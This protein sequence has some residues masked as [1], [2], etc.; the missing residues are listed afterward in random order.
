MAAISGVLFDKDGTL[1]DF[2]QSWTLWTL[3]L[4]Q[5]LAAGDRV[6]QGQMAAELGFD[7]D[8]AAFLPDSPVIAGTP[9]E[10]A[11]CLIPLLPGMSKAA[12]LTR[13]NT[14]AA[15]ANMHEV[16]PLD[17]FLGGLR[18]MGLRV[19]VATNDAEAP[20]VAHLKQ[21]GI[22]DILDF[23]AGCDSGYG[24]KPSAGPL[25]A[26]ADMFDLDP[27]HVVM[28]G[29]SRHDLVAARLAGMRPVA[30]LTGLARESELADLAETVLDSVADL[31]GWL[32]LNGLGTDALPLAD[33]PGDKKATRA[34]A[35]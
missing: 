35:S 27:G 6:R 4:L 8:R 29:D 13:M 25:L 34:V 26:F 30:V 33:C 31:P 14:L 15:E 5:E 2:E 18:G 17:D 20:A 12:L 10:A 9:D 19:G 28:V 22:Y 32:S 23:V 21:A 7:M 3:A 11:D 16:V 24:A 1:F